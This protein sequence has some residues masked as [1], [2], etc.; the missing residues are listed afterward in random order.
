MHHKILTCTAC[1]ALLLLA[2][3]G[4]N[5]APASNTNGGTGGSTAP[6]PDTLDSITTA[7]IAEMKNMTA[8]LSKITDE[9]SANAAALEIEAI[10]R[11]MK[12]LDQRGQKF[13]DASQGMNEKYLQSLMAAADEMSA[14]THRL[15]QTNPEAKK[16]VDEAMKKGE[17]PK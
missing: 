17:S 12:D 9:A 1:S 6:A 10:S 5:D 16:I 7:S 13:G 4:K 8:V 15:A 2:A 11:R 3:C 14:Q